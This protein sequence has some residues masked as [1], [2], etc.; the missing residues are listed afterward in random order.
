MIDTDVA[1]HLLNTVQAAG[2]LGATA[3][4]TGISPKTA[5]TM[6]RLGIDLSTLI[7]K[8]SLRTG[9]REAFGIIGLKIAK[10]SEGEEASEG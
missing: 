9:V 6:T 1:K 2:M 4:I 7:C 5:Q 8:G 10:P 3:I